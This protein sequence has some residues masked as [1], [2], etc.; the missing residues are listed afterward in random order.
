MEYA[1]DIAASVGVRRLVLFHHD[2]ARTDDA[3][4]AVVSAAQARAAADGS[5]LEVSAAA[6]SD[7]IVL[8]PGGGRRPQAEVEVAATSVP[9]LE[10]LDVSVI[11]ATHDAHLEEL[12]RAAAIAEGLKVRLPDEAAKRARDAVVVLDVDDEITGP[13]PGALS[14]LGVTRQAVPSV[15]TNITDWLVLPCTIAHVRTKLHAAVLRRACRW[16]AAPA[17]PDEEERLAALYAQQILDTPAEPRFDRLVEQAR[18]ATETPIALV[19][20]VDAARQWFKAHSGFDISESPRDES[21]CAHAILGEETLQVPDALEDDR[22]AD[23]PAVAGP[24]RVRFYAGVPLALAD[25]S[26]VGTLCVADHRPRLLDDQQLAEL[27]RLA[28]LVVAELQPRIT[29]G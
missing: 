18:R 27:R 9:A 17:P 22:F 10:H 26:R 6:E 4:D 7:E 24:A 23:N 3:L 1:V 12:V 8:E 25:G 13:F 5:T 14:V 20:L 15:A 21:F 2:P 28:A 11:V 29:P 16:R 19:T